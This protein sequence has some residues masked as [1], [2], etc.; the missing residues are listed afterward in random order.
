MG[1]IH[2]DVHECLKDK[3]EKDGNGAFTHVVEAML[4]QNVRQCPLSFSYISTRTA[5]SCRTFIVVVTETDHCDH[6]ANA[7]RE[8]LPVAPYTTNNFRASGM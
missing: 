2:P 1:N 6:H 8:Y 7:H 3:E 4:Q 5:H